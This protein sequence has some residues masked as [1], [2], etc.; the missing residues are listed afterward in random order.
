[1][2]RRRGEFSQYIKDTV[3]ATQ[4]K[5]W[6]CGEGERSGDPW[7]IHHLIYVASRVGKQLPVVIIES[8]YN[9]A[10]VHS[11]CHAKWHKMHLEPPEWVVREVLEAYGTQQLSMDLR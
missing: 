1:M 10:L 11:T 2:A 4:N 8:L 7:H 6:I 3:H 9:A 5:C